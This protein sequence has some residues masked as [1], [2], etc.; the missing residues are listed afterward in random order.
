L[1]NDEGVLCENGNKGAGWVAAINELI[2]SKD[3]GSGRYIQIKHNA[4]K[5]CWEQLSYGRH[6]NDL[7]KVF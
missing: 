4:G 3:K 2:E 1:Q 7:M 5:Y 6:I